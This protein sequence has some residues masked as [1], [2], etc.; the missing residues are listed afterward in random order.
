MGD[1]KFIDMVRSSAEVVLVDCQHAELD[2]LLAFFGSVVFLGET[3]FSTT[4]KALRA[5]AIAHREHQS[6]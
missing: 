5:S 2:I 3:V 4:V 6:S 1:K